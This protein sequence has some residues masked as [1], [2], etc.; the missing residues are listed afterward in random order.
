[1]SSERYQRGL[2]YLHAAQGDEL[3][4]QVESSLRE[5]SESYA[6]FSIASTYGEVFQRDGLELRL[7]QLVTITILATLGGCERQLRLH[8]RAGLRLGLTADEI[9]ETIIQVA[10]YAGAP[11]ASNAV[12]LAGEVFAAEGVRPR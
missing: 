4:D 11:R 6:D 1:L 3:A 10:A 5:I 2:E 9:V 8:I 7:R 12:R